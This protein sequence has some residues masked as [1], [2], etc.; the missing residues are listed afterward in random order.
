MGYKPLLLNKTIYTM[1][2]PFYLFLMIL[3]IP[4][5]L[6]ELLGM[7][8]CSSFP[9]AGP[10]LE[11]QRILEDAMEFTYSRWPKEVIRDIWF[12][13]WYGRLRPGLVQKIANKYKLKRLNWFNPYLTRYILDIFDEEIIP[14]LE[15]KNK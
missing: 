2:M 12:S 5:F 8:V 13:A 14:R 11:Q 15:Y 4:I 10:T 1:E 6:I 9:P 7:W 3:I